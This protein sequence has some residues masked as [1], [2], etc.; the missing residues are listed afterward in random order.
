MSIDT[1]RQTFTS[2]APYYDARYA[3]TLLNRHGT[4]LAPRP[5][6]QPGVPHWVDIVLL[7]DSSCSALL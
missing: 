3:W 4:H 2:R 5:R 7:L 6:A 1:I